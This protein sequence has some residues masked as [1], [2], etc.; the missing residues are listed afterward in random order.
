MRATRTLPVSAKAETRVPAPASAASARPVGARC[1]DTRD[2]GATQGRVRPETESRESRD[3]RGTES[4]G[5]PLQQESC[6][7]LGSRGASSIGRAR[8]LCPRGERCLA[9]RAPGGGRATV[10]RATARR[11]RHASGC[12]LGPPRHRATP[13]LALLTPGRR[14]ASHRARIPRPRDTAAPTPHSPL[15]GGARRSACRRASSACARCPC[16]AS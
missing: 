2:T 10:P 6:T 9:P 8:Q 5:A 4:S 14:T 13:P 16:A 11:L 15:I 12:A 3:A 1:S 7:A